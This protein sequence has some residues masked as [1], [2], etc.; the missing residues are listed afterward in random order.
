M[1]WSILLV[2]VILAAYILHRRAR[3]LHGS[4]IDVLTQAYEYE[5]RT[6]RADAAKLRAEIEKL[7]APKA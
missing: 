4:E 1:F 6:L 2:L 3:E 5:V 7:K